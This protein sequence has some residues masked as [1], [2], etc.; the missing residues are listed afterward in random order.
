MFYIFSLIRQIFYPKGSVFYPKSRR[1]V[2]KIL[3][4]FSMDS[5][6]EIKFVYVEL[7]SLELLLSSTSS[8]LAKKNIEI[9]RCDAVGVDNSIQYYTINVKF[10]DFINRLLTFRLLKYI[11]YNFDDLLDLKF[12]RTYDNLS[13][14]SQ[15]LNLFIFVLYVYIYTLISVYLPTK[16]VFLN[17]FIHECSY[18][19]SGT[20]KLHYFLFLFLFLYRSNIAI[21]EM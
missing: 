3:S 13:K 4:S 15:C 14:D 21:Y 7:Y 19:G 10:N 6:N 1:F 8:T 18:R 12:L 2:G 5:S 11:Y 17:C 16:N 20:S 9:N